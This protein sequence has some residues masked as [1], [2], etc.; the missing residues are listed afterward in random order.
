MKNKHKS[1]NI[2]HAIRYF[3]GGRGF[4]PEELS[5]LCLELSGVL[6]I[7]KRSLVFLTWQI[8]Q[9]MGMRMKRMSLER[10]G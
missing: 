5:R 10:S 7:G 4:L 2:K 8:P 9:Y 6:K 3:T 1:E